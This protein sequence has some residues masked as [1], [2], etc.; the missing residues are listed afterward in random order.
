[1]LQIDL[2]S[3]VPIYE[4]LINSVIRLKSLGVL[5]S[6]E[7]LPSVRSL[8]TELGVNPNTVQK[9]YQMLESDGIIYSV[10]GKGSFISPD[11]S[12]TKAILDNAEKALKNAIS[13]AYLMGISKERAAKLCEEVHKETMERG[14]AK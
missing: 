6:D 9:A 7:Q 2:Q 14:A 12:A 13:S 4:Q 10:T 5:N 11:K 3:R 1:M 8:A